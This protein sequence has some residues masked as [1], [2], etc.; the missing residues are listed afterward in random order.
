M[1]KFFYL[2]LLL[3]TSGFAQSPYTQ[4]NQYCEVYYKRSSLPSL[5]AGIASHGEIVW[6]NY[7][8]YADLE[9]SIRVSKYS[10]YRVASVSKFITAVAVMQLVEQG[11]V[12]LD[13]DARIYLPYFPQKRWGFT[14]RQLLNHTSGI[15]TYKNDEEF[16]SKLNFSS[17]RDAILYVGKDSLDYQP[18]TKYVYSTLAYNL[19]AGIIEQISGVSFGQYLKKNIFEPAKMELTRLDYF[20]QIIPDRVHGYQKNS[21]RQFENAP[22][23]DLTIKFPGGGVLSTV[24]DLLRF[25]DAL[26]QHK[27][28]KKQFLDSMF[29][30]TI[31][32]GGKKL[33]YGLGVDFGIDKYGKKF[34]GHAGGGTGFVSHIMCYPDLDMVSVHLINCRDR[35]LINVAEETAAIFSGD[36]IAEPKYSLSDTLTKITTTVSLDSALSFYKTLSKEKNSEFQISN[37]ELK[38]FGY[39]LLWSNHTKEAIGAFTTIT[40]SDS[41]F[42]DGLVG[43]GDAFN[44]DGNKG[45][46]LRN[47]KRAIKLKPNDQYIQSV[48][49]QIEKEQK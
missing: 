27:L 36:K 4:L 11:K 14:V 38:D 12:K 34:F 23:A 44:K 31:L 5:S 41:S 24:D 18:G 19:L 15:R 8:G 29:T 33:Q 16:N 9:N 48:I 21:L 37:M 1:K 6:S 45:L 25:G 17:L 42:A 10:L 28:L 49:M 3:L 7:L 2:T 30:E 32:P 47:Y 43:L 13:A 39:D 40:E 20:N 22:L 35:N 26:L 46:A